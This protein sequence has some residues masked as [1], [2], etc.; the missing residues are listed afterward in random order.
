MVKRS[1][2]M[3]PCRMQIS[4]PSGFGSGARFTRSASEAYQQEGQSA[5]GARG[6]ALP[7]QSK[8]KNSPQ[9]ASLT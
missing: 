7:A 8:F 5:V 6:L 4:C 1:A 9:I 3:L 2:A